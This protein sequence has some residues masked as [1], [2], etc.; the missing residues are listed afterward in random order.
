MNLASEDHSSETGFTLVELLVVVSVVVVLL[1]LL[2]PSMDKAIYEA[3]MTVCMTNLHSVAQGGLAYTGDYKRRYPYRLHVLSTQGGSY[4]VF[5]MNLGTGPGR[6]DRVIFRGYIVA[7][8]SL[9]CPLNKKLDYD[10]SQ[11]GTLCYSDYAMWMGWQYGGGEQGMFKLG[12]RFTWRDPADGR[13]QSSNVL[14]SSFAQRAID[15]SHYAAHPDNNGL[16]REN[17]EQD[18]HD[19]PSNNTRTWSAF[20]AD[21]RAY[22]FSLNFVMDDHSVRRI[23]RITATSNEDHGV[24]WAWSWSRPA[25]GNMTPL[26]VN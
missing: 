26:P 14:A 22:D 9:N 10:G 6:D 21:G 12:D 11:P 16:W 4:G 13:L 3:E 8:K 15:R 17:N 5:N 19:A 25:A 20:F 7:N 2:A 1:A 24:K 18:H 23:N